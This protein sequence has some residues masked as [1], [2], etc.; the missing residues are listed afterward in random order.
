M[1]GSIPAIA[2]WS[3]LAVGALVTNVLVINN[4]RD[5]DSDG[6]AG[7]RNIPVLFGYRGGESEYIA[8]LVLAY[9]IPVCLWGLGLADVWVLLPWLSIWY[10]AR[11]VLRIHRVPQGRQFNPLLAATASLALY[12]SILL[13]VGIVL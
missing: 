7:R 12:Y 6:A 4:L 1:L 13:A 2:W 9:L 10:T 8:M 3:A 5:R 11:L